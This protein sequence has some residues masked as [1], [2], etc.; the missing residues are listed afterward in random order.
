MSE[1][2]EKQTKNRQKRK[3]PKTAWK[4]G[5]SGN[6]NGR[7]KKEYCISDWIREKGEA[8]TKMDRTRYEE[9]SEVVWARA[10]SAD[11]GFVNIILDRLEGKSIDRIAIKND[12]DDL[13]IL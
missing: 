7:P 11:I 8:R 5:Q 13:I 9:L 1:T 6:P 12:D 2:S 10:L 4:P 3:A